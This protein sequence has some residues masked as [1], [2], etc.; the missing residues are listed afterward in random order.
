MSGKNTNNYINKC[1]KTVYCRLNM[2]TTKGLTFY[3]YVD[4]L[5][6]LC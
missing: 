4:N 1:F 5:Q 6:E 2:L 3:L